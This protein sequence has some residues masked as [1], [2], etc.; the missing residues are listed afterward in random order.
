MQCIDE[1]FAIPF[2]SNSPTENTAQNDD[3]KLHLV[4]LIC[5]P[6]VI[7]FGIG[8][9]I[10]ERQHNTFYPS[11]SIKAPNV[12]ATTEKFFEE[13]RKYRKMNEPK[14]QP[15]KML[16][17]D[18]EEKKDAATKCPKDCTEKDGVCFFEMVDIEEK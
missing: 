18:L 11:D 7:V 14:L 1:K 9:F 15:E 6:L 12:C 8:K 17:D 5:I 2:G 13:E 10:Y 4:W 3:N 16:E